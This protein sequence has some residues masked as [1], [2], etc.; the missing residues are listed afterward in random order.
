MRKLDPSSLFLQNKKQDAPDILE[1]TPRTRKARKCLAALQLEKQALALVVDWCSR[2]RSHQLRAAVKGI[3]EQLKASDS[4]YVLLN[5][6]TCPR[7]FEPWL[8]AV[9]LGDVLSSQQVWDW[10]GKLD[11]CCLVEQRSRTSKLVPL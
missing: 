7:L 6:Q 2:P 4:Y 10:L 1:E 5:P 8:Q 9:G 3:K 11:S